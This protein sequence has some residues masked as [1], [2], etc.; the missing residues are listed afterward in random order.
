VIPDDAASRSSPG[1]SAGMA[2]KSEA[3]A[4]AAVFAIEAWTRGAQLLFVTEKLRDFDKLDGSVRHLNL[5]VP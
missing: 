5:N 2:A 4:D 3:D 1:N